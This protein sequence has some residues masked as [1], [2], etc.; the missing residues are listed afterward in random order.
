MGQFD[1][2]LFGT[3]DNRRWRGSARDLPGDPMGDAGSHF[4]RCV[5]QHAV[6]NWG[7]THVGHVVVAYGVEHRLRLHPAEADIDAS[8]FGDGPRKAPAV[9]VEHRQGPQIYGMV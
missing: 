2:N 1:T 3:L 6:D 8:A 4:G 9:A 5:D 7:A